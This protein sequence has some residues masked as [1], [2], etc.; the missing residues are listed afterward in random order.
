MQ[1]LEQWGERFFSLKQNGTSFQTEFLAGATT[2]ATMSYVLATVPNVLSEAGLPKGAVLTMLILMVAL[3][4][5]AMALYTNKPFAMAPGMS[6]VAVVGSITH[7]AGIPTDVAFGLIFLS[8]LI[9]CVISFVGLRELVVNAIPANVKF[10]ISAGVGL[11]I[12]LIG[13]KTGNIVVTL[14]GGSLGFGD[15]HSTKCLLFGVGFLVLLLLEARR[16]RGSMMVSILVVTLLAIPFGE[17]E[18]PET[19]FQLPAS[20]VPVL[21]HLDILGA[22]RPEYFPYLFTFFVPDFF[23]TMGIILGIANRAGWQDEEGNMPGID[24]C[25]KVDSL[26]TVAGSFCAMPVMTTYLESVSG[27]EDGGRTGLTTLVTSA[28]FILMLLL[29]PVALMIPPVATGPVLTYIGLQMLGAMQNIHY[30]DMTEAIP[31]FIAVA[32][33][34]FTNNIANGLSLSVLCYVLLKVAAGKAKEVHPA[35][36]GLSAFLVYYLSTLIS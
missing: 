19:M 12:A 8:G 6:S 5:I 2:F 24:K 26:A 16:F 14:S 32:M 25:F 36:Y 27:V 21:F 35:M 13:L 11:F 15:L 18:V 3:C 22:L 4:S 34:V 10:S 9:F 31:A 17:T 30:D 33:T 23:G 29:T 28:M 20:P 1:R 7:L